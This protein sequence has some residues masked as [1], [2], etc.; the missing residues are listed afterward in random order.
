MNEF[1]KESTEIQI[2]FRPPEFDFYKGVCGL[3]K[4][5]ECFGSGTGAFP[6][7]ILKNLNKN[8]NT[9]EGFEDKEK[10]KPKMYDEFTLKVLFYLKRY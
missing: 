7:Q 9:Y 5:T 2:G 3:V 10:K 4:E 6:D 1:L 8:S